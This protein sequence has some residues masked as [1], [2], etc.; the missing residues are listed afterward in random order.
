MFKFDKFENFYKYLLN[1]MGYSL[2]K[3]IDEESSLH[4]V[5]ST[6]S[7]PTMQIKNNSIPLKHII[8]K[9]LQYI[10]NF[11]IL[12]LI[13]WSILALI[14]L[15]AT[16][17]N[18]NYIGGAIFHIIFFFHY[19]F[20]LSYYKTDHLFN[21]L[22][23]HSRTKYI[24][25][26][27]MVIAFLSAI[28]LAILNV[29]LFM[30]QDKYLI[31]SYFYSENYLQYNVGMIILIFIDTLYSYLSFFTYAVTFCTIMFYHKHVV[32]SYNQKIYEYVKRPDS[33]NKK[34]NTIALEYTR[35][36]DEFSI[37]VKYLKNFFV[38]L[39]IFGGIG[40]YVTIINLQSRNYNPIGIT[41][42]CIFLIIE[43]I[44]II[45]VES[46]QSHVSDILKLLTSQQFVTSLF[47]TYNTN[48]HIELTAGNH[49]DLQSIGST[50][51]NCLISTLSIDES[52][53]WV[54]LDLITRKEWESFTVFGMKIDNSTI[55]QK[56]FGAILAFLTATSLSDIIFDI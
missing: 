23:K 7:I 17:K 50:L 56:M 47:R 32:K 51:Q 40:F 37:A 16:K 54:V 43:I 20:G 9:K 18:T 53:D 49:H 35:L 33:A 28:S 48:R 22:E 15:V 3:K 52:I 10:Y 8:K 30:K 41:N 13:I 55:L 1:F 2:Y 31:Y 44:Y 24:Y 14:I 26:I 39:N 6:E 5:I 34:I 27:F 12:G 36:K 25:N 42:S 29:F 45:S 21:I 4:L 38:S 19:I 46:V 11:I